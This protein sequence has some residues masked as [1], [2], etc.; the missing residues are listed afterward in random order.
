MSLLLPDV[1]ILINA[2]RKEAPHH[3][4]C[5]QWLADTGVNG[6]TIGLCE[7]VEV[8]FLR[9]TTLPRLQLAPM[10]EALEFWAKD[11]WS[12]PRICRLHPQASHS[13]ILSGIVTELELTGND[14]NDAWLAALAIGH[15]A[16][17]VSLDRGFARF[18][19]LDWLDP[20]QTE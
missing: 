15:R 1:N 11:L 17:L 9:I 7:S 14:L 2:F 6:D 16:T 12:H 13:T 19:E 4:A 18:P 20:S 8:A 3:A 5:A 10:G